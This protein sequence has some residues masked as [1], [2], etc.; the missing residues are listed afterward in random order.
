MTFYYGSLF[1]KL[2]IYVICNQIGL[3]V[4][5]IFNHLGHL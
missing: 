4:Y 5:V 2:V 1:P 3:V